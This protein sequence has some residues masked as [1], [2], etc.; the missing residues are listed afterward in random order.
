MVLR[1]AK[2]EGEHQEDEG[3]SKS[4]LWFLRPPN[5]Q[6][7]PK[8]HRYP[9]KSPR[10]E[11][12]NT[13]TSTPSP[14]K[15]T[16][17]TSTNL[18]TEFFFFWGGE[19]EFF[20]VFGFSSHETLERRTVTRPG[21]LRVPSFRG[22]RRWGTSAWVVFFFFGSWSSDRD[23]YGISIFGIFFCIFCMIMCVLCAFDVFL[24]CRCIYFIK[25]LVGFLWLH[26]PFKRWFNLIPRG[27]RQSAP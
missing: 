11:G 6:N 13:K 26:W 20:G 3:D 25:R 15:T 1:K 19:N 10:F 2:P 27:S 18:Q 9:N 21:R 8:H 12:K 16:K 22:R 23:L 17:T 7:S 5:H 24:K 4:K 14:Q